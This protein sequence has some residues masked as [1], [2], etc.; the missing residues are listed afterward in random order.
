MNQKSSFKDVENVSYEL[1][2]PALRWHERYDRPV[3][4]AEKLRFLNVVE[5]FYHSTRITEWGMAFVRW[6][7]FVGEHIRPV[8]YY[9][10]AEVAAHF[11]L[12]ERQTLRNLQ[13]LKKSGLL[14]ITTYFDKNGR[15]SKYRCYDCTPFLNC[16]AELVRKHVQAGQQ[17]VSCLVSDMAST[18]APESCMTLCPP[19]NDHIAG[20]SSSDTSVPTAVISGVMPESHMTACSSD[21]ENIAEDWDT[22]V[23]NGA[24]LIDAPESC[25][26]LCP[27]AYECAAGGCSSSWDTS[28]PHSTAID[29]TDVSAPTSATD[30]A[31]NEPGM[32]WMSI[33]CLLPASNSS[34]SFSNYNNIINISTSN[35]KQTN[36]QEADGGFLIPASFFTTSI[37]DGK[38]CEPQHCER[39][40]YMVHHEFCPATASEQVATESQQAECDGLLEQCAAQAGEQRCTSEQAAISEPACKAATGA[41]K[42]ACGSRAAARQRISALLAESRAASDAELGAHAKITIHRIARAFHDMAAYS[43]HVQATTLYRHLLRINQ[44]DDKYTLPD[45]DLFFTEMMQETYERLRH[46][47]FRRTDSQRRP[48]GMPLFFTDLREQVVQLVEHIQR[49]RAQDAAV[50]SAMPESAQQDHALPAW[51]PQQPL[52]SVDELLSVSDSHRLSQYVETIPLDDPEELVAQARRLD[53]VL[54]D[55]EASQILSG[56]ASEQLHEQVI[57]AVRMGFYYEIKDNCVVQAGYYGR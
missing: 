39:M 13:A 33:F 47:E 22:S 27:S 29:E 56:T 20:A 40:E 8:A 21:D 46:V 1:P 31:G 37:D 19:D 12:S 42:H 51:R 55:E 43:S 11:H 3:Q 7:V 54:S 30:D 36:A 45:L 52:T 32:S 2:Q 10:L 49:R 18:V 48:N 5:M 9:K 28:V 38:I 23:S 24:A 14:H 35:S 4:P 25:M 6:I 34:T 41:S 57:Q 17:Q 53:V 50:P 16:I 44:V 15:R 26:T